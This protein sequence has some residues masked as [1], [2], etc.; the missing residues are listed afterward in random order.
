[1]C[2]CLF[3]VLFYNSVNYKLLKIKEKSYSTIVIRNHPTQLSFFW[4]LIH[5][6]SLSKSWLLGKSWLRYSLFEKISILLK[7]I[8]RDLRILV[9]KK[10]SNL[11]SLKVCVFCPGW[12]HLV[13]ECWPMNEKGAGSIPSQGTYLGCRP[14][15]Q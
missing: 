3:F 4:N 5:L 2:L 12:C 1:M 10:N 8:W 7:K 13:V 15:P 9:L 11:C 6:A 14:G